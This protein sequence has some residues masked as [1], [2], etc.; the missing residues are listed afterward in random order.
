MLMKY[1]KMRQLAIAISG[2]DQ[3]ITIVTRKNEGMPRITHGST[4]AQH[5]IVSLAMESKEITKEQ[6]NRH[7]VHAIHKIGRAHV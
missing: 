2:D 3:Q 7:V 1:F 4:A 5:A 6:F